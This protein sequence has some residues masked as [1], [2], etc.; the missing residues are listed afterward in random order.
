MSGSLLLGL[1]M[2]Y[3]VLIIGLVVLI[4]VLK[5]MQRRQ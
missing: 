5:M 3:W 2:W 4:V 1:G